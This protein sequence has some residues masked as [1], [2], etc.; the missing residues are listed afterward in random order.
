[1]K[2][3]KP[4]IVR[5]SRELARVLNLGPSDARQLE[6]H[7]RMLMDKSVRKEQRAKAREIQ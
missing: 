5:T 1:M 7:A 2:E 4:I 3:I 6:H